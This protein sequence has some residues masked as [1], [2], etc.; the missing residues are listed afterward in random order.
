MVQ[1]IFGDGS[2][3]LGCILNQLAQS[4]S[5]KIVHFITNLAQILILSAENESNETQ[6]KKCH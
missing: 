6:A 4:L 3:K 1:L 5:V 2:S